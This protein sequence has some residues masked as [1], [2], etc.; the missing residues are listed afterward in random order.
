MATQTRRHATPSNGIGSGIIRSLGLIAL[1]A[2]APVACGSDDEADSGSSTTADTATSDNSSSSTSDTT[3]GTD[4]AQGTTGSTQGTDPGGTSELGS[5][6]FELSTANGDVAVRGTSDG[7]TNPSET[8]LDVTFTDGTSE[9]VVSAEDGVGS[10]IIPGLFEG[11]IDQIAV[12]DLGNV[13]ISGRGGLADDSAEPTTFEVL[14]NC[15]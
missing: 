10:V 13:M 9:V 4:S 8:T 14:G 3:S 7:C 15:A 5:L 6:E 1:L 2:V 11:T 12:G